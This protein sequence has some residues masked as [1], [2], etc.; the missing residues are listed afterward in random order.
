MGALLYI[1][2]VNDLPEV[3]HQS[4]IQ[5]YPNEH[6][7]YSDECGGVCSYVDDSTYVFASENAETLSRKLSLEYR[8]LASYLR[9]NKL[10]INDE[11]TQLLV[12]GMPKFADLR[13]SVF[14]Q[15]GNQE[16]LPSDQEAN[17]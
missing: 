11:K 17:S 7:S 15:A 6:H 9:S 1:L 12:T 4:N 14:L 8:N 2:F 13:K 10:V 5:D 16:I 3:V